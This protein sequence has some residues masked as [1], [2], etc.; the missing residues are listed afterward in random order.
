MA[1]VPLGQLG[2]PASKSQ[3][4]VLTEL[5]RKAPP[6]LLFQQGGGLAEPW[7]GHFQARRSRE[8]LLW[9]AHGE[10]HPP[11]GLSVL[12]ERHRSVPSYRVEIECG[13][14]KPTSNTL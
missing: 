12:K 5:G 6:T 4:E 13:Q 9:S 1:T 2:C 3:S 8:A 14:P 11:S 7:V 10:K